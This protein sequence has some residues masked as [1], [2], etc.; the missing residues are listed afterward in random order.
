[1]CSV[2]ELKV[3]KFYKQQPNELLKHN[4]NFFTRTY[5]KGTRF[6]SSN[7]SPVEAWALGCHMVAL[8][9]Q[10]GDS[11]M[12]VNNGRFLDNGKCGYVLK[13]PAILAPEKTEISP[14][15]I[16][17]KIIS[18]WQLPKVSGTSKGEVIDPFVRVEIFGVG[19]D[20]VHEKTKVVQNNGYNP[21]WNAEMKF[22][23]ERSDLANILIEVYDEDKLSKND[24]IA[25]ASLPVTSLREGYRSVMLY[26]S[27]SHKLP[28][29]SLL[30]HVA[31]AREKRGLTASLT[32]S[33]Q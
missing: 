11:G 5:P 23:V 12:F 24:F 1:M 19:N 18:G 15:T 2:S 9:Y 33:Q 8:N 26:S 25:Y 6:D 30:V 10:T 28:E 21:Q 13:P 29:A 31:I 16:T 3:H 32:A 20:Q 27:A 4:V 17:L 22:V 14:I 7:Y